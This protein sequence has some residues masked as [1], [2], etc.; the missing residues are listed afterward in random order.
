[1]FELNALN[2]GIAASALT[3]VVVFLGIRLAKIRR[4]AEGNKNL[5][6]TRALDAL[7][8]VLIQAFQEA[9]DFKEAEKDGYESVKAYVFGRVNEFVRTTDVLTDAEKALLTSARVQSIL[10]PFLKSL[11]DY[12]LEPPNKNMSKLAMAKSQQG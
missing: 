7:R 11:W 10:E 4:E 1:M 8:E 3:V 12:K 9:I 2:V 6:L 5:F